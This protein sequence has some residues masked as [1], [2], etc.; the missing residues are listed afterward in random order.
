MSSRLEKRDRYT[1]LPCKSVNAFLGVGPEGR[2]FVYKRLLPF[3]EF[4]LLSQEL[5]TDNT[6]EC[7]ICCSEIVYVNVKFHLKSLSGNSAI[8]IKHKRL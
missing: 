5:A 6:L 8:F 2:A 4:S 1:V 7:N 3:L